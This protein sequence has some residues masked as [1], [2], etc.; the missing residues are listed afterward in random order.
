[1]ASAHIKVDQ[2]SK[3]TRYTVRW[4]PQSGSFRKKT[5][6]NKRE[7]ERFRDRI[8]RELEEGN[9]TE[10]LAGRSKTFRQ[11]A[12]QMIAASAHLK[13]KTLDGYEMALRVH[14][15]PAFGNRRISVLKASDIDHWIADLRAKP[16]KDGTR[17]SETS[18][19]GTYKVVRK[20]FS[21]AYAHR[22]IPFN[23]CIAVTKPKADTAEARF[24]TVQ[25]IDR[26]AHELA[27]Q[28][29]YDLLVRF[30][31]LTGL[32][33]GE[34]AALRIRD[35]DLRNAL[36]KVELSKTHTSKGYITAA[37]KT[38]HARRDVPILDDDLFRDIGVYL[39]HHPHRDNL[40]A[41]LWP[42]K[43][44]GHNRLSYDRDFDPKGFY[45]YT[46]KPAATR[47][48]LDGLHFHELRHTF[49]TL[50]LE[51]RAL[52]MFE[53]S[54]AMGH[55]NQDITDR[56]YA[57]VRPRDF[58]AHRAAFSAGIKAARSQPT[59]IRAIGG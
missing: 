24:L 7:A 26:L 2:T 34:V 32:R 45:R 17:R 9:S 5:S 33:L 53:L 23:P 27:A 8:I 48:G 47:A 59:P 36:V 1:M 14:A 51:L 13:Q 38:A 44:P 55:A 12:E 39:R 50:A 11:A 10:H 4:R 31:A 20:V 52:D 58:S 40:E 18:V 6:Y 19:L 43:V 15:Y 16:K 3:G 42:G 28:P 22:L 29:P 25:E 30:A 49:A 35:I 54:R 21:Y 46:F 37:P 56:V 41:G 57:H